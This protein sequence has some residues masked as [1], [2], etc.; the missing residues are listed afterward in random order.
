MYENLERIEWTNYWREDSHGKDR[1][2]LIGDSISNGYKSIVHRELGGEL[3][4]SAM[5][6][7]KSA[8][9]PHFCEE[10]EMIARQEDYCYKL[11]QLNSGLHSGGQSEQEYEANLEKIILFIQKILPNAILVLA[12]S[13]PTTVKNEPSNFIE[14]SVQ[15]YNAAV[16]R[17]GAKYG[18]PVND[19][20]SL[21]YGNAEIRSLDGYHYI[22]E[23]NELL[24]KKV[25]EFIRE[26]LK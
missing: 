15:K 7:S 20:Y 26:N 14:G 18:L 11:V 22:A 25:T 10:I 5:S 16:D 13:T 17:L 23:G 21:V 1:I 2:L 3:C 4:I 24:G 9:N 12:N 19:L 8:A 6:T